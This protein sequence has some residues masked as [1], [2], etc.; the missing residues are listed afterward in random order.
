LRIPVKMD[1]DSGGCRSPVPDDADQ[2]FRWMAIT[3]RCAT[4]E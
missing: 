4:L 3:R 2:L 1:A